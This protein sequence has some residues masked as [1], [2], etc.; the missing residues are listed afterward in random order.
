MYK[1][2][3]G[4]FY[5]GAYQSGRSVALADLTDIEHAALVNYLHCQL[6]CFNLIA[7]FREVIMVFD[8]CSPI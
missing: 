3:R 8:H 1:F 7:L 4:F 5:E 2:Y 6:D